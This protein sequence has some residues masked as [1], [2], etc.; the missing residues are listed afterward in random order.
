MKKIGILT[1][2]FGANYGAKAHSYALQNVISHLGYECE[3]ISFFPKKYKAINLKMNL[4]KNHREKSFI[5]TINGL[6]RLKELNDINYIFKFSQKVQTA[7][8]IDALGYDLIILGS[9]EVFN[10]HHPMFNDIYFGVGL[11][12]P[13]ITYAP[14][15]GYVGAET[16]LPNNIR[17][18]LSNLKAISVRDYHTQELLKNNGILNTSVVVDPT[19]LYNFSDIIE[20]VAYDKYLLVYSFSKWNEYANAFRD[21]ANEKGWKILSIGRYCEWA[22]L[23]LDKIS[24]SGWISAYRKAEMVVTDSFHGAIFSI[25]NNKNIILLGRDDKKDKIQDLFRL[26]SIE[27]PFWDGT[28]AIRDYITC[29]D[30]IDVSNNSVKKEINKSYLWIENTLNQFL[31]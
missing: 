8:E 31:Q 26:L 21:Y 24:F 9:D 15:S 25:K 17:N 14:S 30:D 1:W 27:K 18:S 11:M 19:L 7:E 28:Q 16:V 10:I 12:T 4:D 13:C 3:F 22:D 5:R 29:T 6:G 20:E 23:S 2:W